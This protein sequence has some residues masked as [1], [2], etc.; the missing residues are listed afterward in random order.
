[1]SPLDGL[2][3]IEHFLDGMGDY[4]ILISDKMADL[5]QQ[6]FDH[7]GLFLSFAGIV[8]PFVLNLLYLVPVVK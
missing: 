6:G 2:G 1:M 5:C 7:V 3:G 4:G 8:V